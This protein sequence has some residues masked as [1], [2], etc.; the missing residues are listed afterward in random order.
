[1][2]TSKAKRKAGAKLLTYMG[3]EWGRFAPPTVREGNDNNSRK[4]VSL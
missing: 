3:K 1:M 4:T 2:K